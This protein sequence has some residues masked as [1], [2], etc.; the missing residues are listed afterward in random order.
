MVT[1]C[2]GDRFFRD[3]EHESLLRRAGFGEISLPLDIRKARPR[4]CGLH[5][6]MS[7]GL[8]E[9]VNSREPVLGFDQGLDGLVKFRFRC[10]LFY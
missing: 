9:L 8:E 10:L 4:F 6:D 7:Q 1:L 3:T 2:P 5:S